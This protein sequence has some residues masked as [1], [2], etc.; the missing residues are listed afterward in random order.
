MEGIETIIIK[1]EGDAGREE[2][3]REA[4]QVLDEDGLVAFPTETVYGVGCRVDRP[5]AV[6]RLRKLKGRSEEK[7]FTV[8]VA[9]MATA[10]QVV[11]GLRGTAK[12]MM[13]KAWPGPL[14]LVLPVVNPSQT[15]LVKKI[16]ESAMGAM[17]YDGRIGLRC[18][19]DPVSQLL[20]QQLP[21]PIVAA[22][23]NFA[24]QPAAIEGQDIHEDLLK[25]VELLI[26]VGPTQ[27]RKASTIVSVD[28]GGVEILRE[29]V[30]DPRMIERLATLK[31][32]FVCTGN[33]CRSPMAE[34]IASQWLAEHFDCQIEDLN[35]HDVEVS[36]AG[37]LGGC[38]GANEQA[39]EVIRRR[40]VRLEGHNSRMLTVDMVEQADY[41][42]A[43]TKSHLHGILGLASHMEDRVCL[44][45][46]GQEVS[47]PIGGSVNDYE[48]CARGIEVGVYARLKEI[49]L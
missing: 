35:Q 41:V 4:M 30:L 9:D 8:H 49:D 40:G 33:T 17:Y 19:S 16:G 18:P 23:A 24:G 13:R 45:L 46:D 20:L 10:D 1:P 28:D 11:P 47:D 34:A 26:D 29:G 32:L 38:G 44:L 37:L 5:K 31:I 48:S 42:F 6:D 36:S 14:T 3:V 27:Y 39:V 21:V 2:A 15:A 12:R 7:A 25:Q 22:S 43:M